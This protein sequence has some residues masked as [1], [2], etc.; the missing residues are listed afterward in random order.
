MRERA[1]QDSG[2]GDDAE[3][4]ASTPVYL[5]YGD[6]LRVKDAARRLVD[7]LCPADQQV[8][9]LEEIE[10]SH[11]TGDQAVA[12]VRRVLLAVDTASFLGGRK[13]VWF[14]A[15][16]FLE[17]GKALRAAVVVPWLDRLTAHIRE[18]LPAGHQLIVTCTGVDRR[19][20]FYK[21]CNDKGQAVAY[22]LPEKSWEI[23]R[24]AG[25]LVRSAL[26][27]AGMQM[28]AEALTAFIDAVGPDARTIRSE[29][30]KLVLYVEGR[31]EIAVE[32]VRAITSPA[33]EVE[34]WDLADRVGARDAP[35]ALAVLRRL[36]QQKVDPILMVGGLESRFR[37][38]AVFRDALDR[39]WLRFNGRETAWSRDSDAAAAL[40]GLGEW[41]PSRMHPFRA[42]KLAEQARAFSAAEIARAA[43]AITRTREQMAGGFSAADLLMEMLVLR[44]ARR[45]PR[46]R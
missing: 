39:G 38:L 46:A 6:D 13:L 34:G 9:G 16:G 5:L 25:A 3:P 2:T 31:K 27:P 1:G 44:I 45:A 28:S 40:A 32:D 23:E 20:A 18:G 29:V 17:S 24:Y 42:G 41:N 10:S 7:A 37:D 26:A 22:T 8:F 21:A 4:S 30:E 35:G 11:D 14:R 19:S 43:S 36:L 15:G 33:R 12:T